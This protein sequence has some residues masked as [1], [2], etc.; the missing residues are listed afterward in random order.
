M[1][2]VDKNDS[3]SIAVER[4]DRTNYTKSHVKKYPHRVQT[5][6]MGVRP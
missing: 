3:N 1:P 2:E 4:Q 6:Q 5:H